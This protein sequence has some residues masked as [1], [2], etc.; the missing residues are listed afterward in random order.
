MPDGGGFR[1]AELAEHDDPRTWSHVRVA[2]KHP[3]LTKT[4]FAARVCRPNVSS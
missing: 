4:Y 1:L 2:A 3:C